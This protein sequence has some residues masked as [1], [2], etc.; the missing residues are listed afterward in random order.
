MM[1]VFSLEPG[2]ATH[3]ELVIGV[4]D[5]D[6]VF[7][8]WRVG[9]SHEFRAA[10]FPVGTDVDYP[11]FCERMGFGDEP[12]TAYVGFRV[13]RY[14]TTGRDHTPRARSAAETQSHRTWTARVFEELDD[15]RKE[16]GL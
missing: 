16:A 6:K 7:F 2:D 11:Y 13:F 1:Q 14:L 4:A 3:Y 12:Y 8:G 10:L 15:I 5:E 9:M